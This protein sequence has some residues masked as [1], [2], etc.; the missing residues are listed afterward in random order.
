VRPSGKHAGKPYRIVQ[1]AWKDVARLP[2]IKPGSLPAPATAQ[3]GRPD[4]IKDGVRHNELFRHGL[5]EVNCGLHPTLTTND[6]A[7]P[8]TAPMGH[9]RCSLTAPVGDVCCT[10]PSTCDFRLVGAA[11]GGVWA[12]LGRGGAARCPEALEE[13]PES[14]AR[15]VLHLL[16]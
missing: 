15:H 4:R 16:Q 2:T 5:R 3:Q 12:A 7:Q 8:E 9:D 6:S 13:S 14:R 11:Y 10:P 1:G